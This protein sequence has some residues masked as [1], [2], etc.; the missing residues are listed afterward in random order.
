VTAHD[1]L[2]L[3]DPVSYNDKHNGANGEE[4]RDGTSENVSG[5]CGVE[6]AADG[7]TVVALRER[8]MRNF[9][10]TLFLSQGVPMLPDGDA[11]LPGPAHRG[12]GGHGSLLVP[13]DGKAVTQAEWKKG[14]TRGPGFRLAGDAIEEVDETGRSIRDDTFPLLL[15]AHHEPVDFVLPAHR[16]RMRWELV[17]DTRSR[18]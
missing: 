1:G 12:L 17:L 13:A 2:T 18:P 5:N 10:T 11:L 9:L 8:Q 16:P 14:L 6:G 3:L 4:H 15:K 7:P